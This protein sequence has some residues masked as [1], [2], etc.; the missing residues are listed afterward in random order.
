MTA[1]YNNDPYLTDTTNNDVIY[2]VTPSGADLVYGNNISTNTTV[3][4]DQDRGAGAYSDTL[5]LS[6]NNVS[7]HL[8]TLVENQEILFV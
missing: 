6:L 2:M 4:I 8:T 5:L 7:N 1:D 3:L